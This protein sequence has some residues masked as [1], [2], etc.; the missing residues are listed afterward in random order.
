VL[1][2][3]DSTQLASTFEEKGK[4]IVMTLQAT[5]PSKSGLSRWV[6]RTGRIVSI[7]PIMLAIASFAQAGT[8]VI[9]SAVVNQTANT[10]TITGTNL[11]GAAS[12]GVSSVMVES[13]T[14][15][16]ITQT[17]TSITAS[18]PSRAPASSLGPG[19]YPGIVSFLGSMAPTSV[20]FSATISPQTRLLFTFVT[21]S[22]GFDTGLAISNITLDPTIGSPAVPGTCTLN[23]E[24]V[25]SV[26]PSNTP[27][28]QGGTAFTTLVSTTAPGFNG[29]VIALCNF[30]AQ[31]VAFISNLAQGTLT[32]LPAVI[33]P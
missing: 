4:R 8:P 1:A 20:S 26:P 21:N 6:A 23:F 33:N 25:A 13:I 31:G 14:L 27:T 2:W 11:L 29:Y 24:G 16:V 5:F 3:G 32:A 17:T 9:T 7:L 28:I 30:K 10:L 22:A 19:T 12:A 15:S 18:F